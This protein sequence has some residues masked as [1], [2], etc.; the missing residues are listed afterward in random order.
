M[1]EYVHSKQA[2]F[3]KSFTSCGIME[4][5]H[6][7]KLTPSATCFAIANALYHKANPRPTAF[8]M[9][10]DVVQ[11]GE[12]SRGQ[13]LFKYISSLGGKVGEVYRSKDEINPKTGNTIFVVIVRISHESFRKWYQDELANRVE[14]TQ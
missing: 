1:G 12:V 2:R 9:F 3:D 8:F 14:E 5:H 11:E 10:S 7:P 4:V 13:A 6:L